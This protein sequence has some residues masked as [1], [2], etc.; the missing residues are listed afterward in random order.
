MSDKPY[1]KMSDLL[2]QTGIDAL[3]PLILVAVVGLL[4]WALR[5]IFGE[6]VKKIWFGKFF[7]DSAT[8]SAKALANELKVAELKFR[9][10]E[11]LVESSEKLIQELN[12]LKEQSLSDAR[13]IVQLRRRVS[14]LAEDNANLRKNLLQCDCRHLQREPANDLLDSR[15]LPPRVYSEVI[16]NL[17]THWD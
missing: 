10:L 7:P 17:Y 15:R 4:I 5:A 2:Y 12:A 8:R 3:L 16:R 6:Y 13:K 9:E 14:N 1:W 11:W